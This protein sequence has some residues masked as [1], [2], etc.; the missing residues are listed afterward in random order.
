VYELEQLAAEVGWVLQRQR[1]M[2]ATAESCTGGLVA[3]LMTTMAG[4]STWFERGW[5]TYSNAAKMEE[6]GVD[7]A[8]LNT[9]GA[10]SKD[11]VLAMAQG[12]IRQSKAHVS[13][14]VSGIAG[15]AGGTQEKPVGTVWLAW[16]QKLGYAEAEVFHFEGDRQAVREQAADRVLRG[17]LKRLRDEC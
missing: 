12:A 7:A 11:C 10:V 6:L 15:P 9:T 5:V 14:A 2:L 1:L 8:I 17:L 16:G 4:S 3:M 13:L